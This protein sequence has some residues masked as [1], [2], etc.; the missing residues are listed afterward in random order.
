VYAYVGTFVVP[1]NLLAVQVGDVEYTRADVVDY[2]RFNQRLAEEAGVDFPIGTSLFE[3]MQTIQDNEIAIQ[4]ASRFG[5]TVD[6]EEV[7]REVERLL[8]FNAQSEEE[9]NSPSYQRDLAESKRQFLNKVGLPEE[10]WRGI[11]QK[12]LFQAK[13]RTVLSADVPRIQPHAHV[14]HITLERNDPQTLQRI[15]RDLAGGAP[16]TSVTRQYSIDPNILRDSGEIGWYPQR[17]LPTLDSMMFELN[18]DG[19]RRLPLRQPSPPTYDSETRLYTV[20]IVDELVEARE[21]SDEN[22]S[23]LADRA[24]QDFLNQE[25]QRYAADG[26]LW[27]ELNSVVYD[28]V[29]K[30]V[31]LSSLRPTATP[32]SNP[33]GIPGLSQ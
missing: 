11:V 9:R 2:I 8:G 21:V 27:M 22:F 16:V 13:I 14:Y 30:Q 29:N 31:R 3:A 1:S 17:V 7:D 5:V 15:E 24:L 10:V 25:R 6:R 4:V 12:T 33:L 28:W 18:A 19:T 32:S 20:Y 23:V 26:T